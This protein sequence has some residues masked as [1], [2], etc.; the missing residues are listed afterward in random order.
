M[1][2]VF[3]LPESRVK[4]LEISRCCLFVC[5]G[6]KFIIICLHT[7]SIIR[8]TYIKYIDSRR[9]VHTTI[10][11]LKLKC[12]EN[13]CYF[14]VLSVQDLNGIRPVFLPF[15]CFHFT[16]SSFSSH[17]FSAHCLLF[18]IQISKVNV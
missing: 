4:S 15:Y 16:L 7:F 1:S 5:C 3:Q 12:I 8:I 13:A 17:L 14:R 9:H 2:P 18:C 10:M 11:A 6:K